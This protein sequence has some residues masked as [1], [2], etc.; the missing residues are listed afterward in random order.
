MT[1]KM[2]EISD[3]HFKRYQNALQ[4]LVNIMTSKTISPMQVFT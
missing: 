3:P 1:K 4:K 2:L